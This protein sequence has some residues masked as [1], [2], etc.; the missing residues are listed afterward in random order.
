MQE[1]A[2]LARSVQVD[3]FLTTL[4]N[5]T[6]LEEQETLLQ[7]IIARAT[8]QDLR[9]I[10]RMIK[11]DLRINAGPKN[12]LAA[13]DDDAYEVCTTDIRAMFRFSCCNAES[14]LLL[15]KAESHCR[16][17]KRRMI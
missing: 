6:K 3:E 12:I 15:A 11:H 5:S 17:S 2:N 8:S 9:Y 14:T 7:R 1:K 10:V 4:S 13:L 16:L